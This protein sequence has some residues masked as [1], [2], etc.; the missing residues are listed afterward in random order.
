MKVEIR[1]YIA[2]FNLSGEIK[3]MRKND[4]Q[5]KMRP[6]SCTA[7]FVDF[8]YKRYTRFLYIVGKQS[9]R[10]DAHMDWWCDI[11]LSS[12]HQRGL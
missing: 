4:K 8:W 6:I 2:K 9:D 1:K 11:D 3:K 5:N 7:C 12:I 10:V